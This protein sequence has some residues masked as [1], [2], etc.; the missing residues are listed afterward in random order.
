[1]TRRNLYAL[2]SLTL[3]F[4]FSAV[5]NPIACGQDQPVLLP[6]L[7]L[8]EPAPHAGAGDALPD[9]HL[10]A[11]DGSVKAVQQS[12]HPAVAAS[13]CQSICDEEHW[14]ISA[15]HCQQRCHG[16]AHDCTL[17]YVR[18]D[19]NGCATP[20]TDAEFRAWLK[21]GVPVCIM[22]HGSYVTADTV[23]DDSMNTFRWLRKAAPH[24]PLQVI[25]L[26]WPS[27]G[28]LTLNPAIATSSPIPGLDVALLG[29]RAEFN[30][31]R[32]VKLIQLISPESPISLIGHSH[33]AR[34]VTSGLNLLGG[35]ELCGVRLC[36]GPSHRIRTILAGAAIDHDWL[37][38]GQRY[39]RALDATECLLNLRVRQDWA[40][41]L[42]PLRRPFSSRALGS[43]GFT[44]GD[45][46]RLGPRG[47]QVKNYDISELIGYRHIWP[48]FYQ[49]P[50]LADSLVP[51]IYFLD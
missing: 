49:H 28:F 29:R 45:I 8:P 15:R 30:G 33:G 38:P 41:L 39:E 27:E 42:Y 35:G 47:S 6:N 43:A 32:L 7:Q 14:I 13:T 25:F 36:D 40:L 20:S 51:W 3:L 46:R 11:I 16:C 34:I 9:G 10:P 4:L 48:E 26:T 12:P 24:L 44:P 18:S 1:M 21:P 5:A 50:S 31:I 19:W 2:F 23:T 22:V 37:C 17:G